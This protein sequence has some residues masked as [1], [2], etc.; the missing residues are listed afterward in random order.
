L[1]RRIAGRKRQPHCPLALLDSVFQTVFE[2]FQAGLLPQ[3]VK[4]LRGDGG[5]IAGE[6]GQPRHPQREHTEVE[7]EPRRNLQALKHPAT[8]ADVAATRRIQPSA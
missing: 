5:R 2:P 4:R 6:C 1:L 8:F 7:H 3:P